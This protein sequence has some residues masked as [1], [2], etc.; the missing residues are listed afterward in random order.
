MNYAINVIV[1]INR[2]DIFLFQRFVKIEIALPKRNE[3]VDFQN[4]RNEQITSKKFC[5]NSNVTSTKGINLENK[6]TVSIIIV[7]Q[8]LTYKFKKIKK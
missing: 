1:I 6:R 5:D 2:T 4:I 7:M 8:S 3:N